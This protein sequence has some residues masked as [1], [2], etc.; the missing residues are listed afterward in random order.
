MP[1]TSTK[2]RRARGHIRRRG[3]SFQVLVYAGVDPLTGKDHYLTES[4]RDEREAQK[5]LTRLLGQVDEQRNPRTK[6][7]L[8]A[9]LDAW[10]RTH[11]AEE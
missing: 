4:T 3:G 11:E 5:I 7:T 6:A 10:L 8:G 9:A 2:T 1:R